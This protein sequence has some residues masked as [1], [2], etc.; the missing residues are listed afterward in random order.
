MMQDSRIGEM[1]VVI[2]DVV[3]SRTAT[4]RDLPT[5]K[6]FYRTSITWDR[7]NNITVIEDNVHTDNVLNLAHP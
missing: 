5:D 3:E 1:T 4:G 7:G 2:P 6:N